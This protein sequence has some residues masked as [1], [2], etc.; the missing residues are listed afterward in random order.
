MTVST[1]NY[2]AAQTG[3]ETDNRRAADEG[4]YIDVR[5]R[6]GDAHVVRIRARMRRRSYAKNFL[7]ILKNSPTS[8]SS[9]DE[10]YSPRRA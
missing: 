7:I 9:S 6:V 8:C 3:V 2:E 10:M 1:K 5:N 4:A